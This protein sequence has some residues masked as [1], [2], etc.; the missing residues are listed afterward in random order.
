MNAHWTVYW[1]EKVPTVRRPKLHAT[2]GEVGELHFQDYEFLEDAMED[3][4][5][6]MGPD[7]D[8]KMGRVAE[9][10]WHP[11]CKQMTGKS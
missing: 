6:M 2:T 8:P 9:L 1:I 3:L 4:A 7:R 10:D 11:L 5:R